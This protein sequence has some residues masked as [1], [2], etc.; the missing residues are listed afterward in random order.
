VKLLTEYI[1]R[2]LQLESL[3]ELETDPGFSAELVKQA[4]AYRKIA[5]KRA[6][7]YGLPPPSPPAKG[8]LKLIL[9]RL[10]LFRPE[11]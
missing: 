6:E 5:A 4:N 11:H 7:Q 8:G 3:A 2:A 10:R 9:P 1:E